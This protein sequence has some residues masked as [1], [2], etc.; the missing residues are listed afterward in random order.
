MEK[1][2]QDNSALKLLITKQVVKLIR[3]AKSITEDQKEALITE[4]GIKRDTY[5]DQVINFEVDFLVE[6]S[7]K[8][9]VSEWCRYGHEEMD[10]WK[11]VVIENAKINNDPH[12]T[13]DKVIKS[14]AENFHLK[15]LL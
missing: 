13:A 10:I 4:V 9:A 7:Q 11:K 2:N 5:R 6:K 8:Y 3:S 15:N 12:E 14:L 1:F